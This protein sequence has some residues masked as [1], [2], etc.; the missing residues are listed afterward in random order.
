M[1]GQVRLD[2]AESVARVTLSHPGKLNAM[3]RVMWQQLR[4]VFEGIQQN[5]SLRCVIL[6]GEG[7][8]FCAGGDISEYADF[9][10][11]E[12]TLRQF[13]DELVW[14]GLQALLDCDVPVVAQI[15]GACMGAGLEIA[16]C[17]DLRIAGM[18]AKFG[19]PIAKLG[20]P[21]APR[22]LALVICAAGELS[23]REMLLSAAVLD[24]PTAAQRG[25]LNRVS[26]DT[27]V[28][29]EA[30]AMA[31]RVAR[32]APQAARLNKQSFRALAHTQRALAAT[33]LI[34]NAYAY[35]ASAEHREG[36]TAFV[37]KRSPQF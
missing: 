26:P 17:C 13:H 32:L 19:A 23:A 33:D 18:S 2:I 4:Q 12:A 1:T 22:E 14:G 37:D 7:G 31:S 27:E 6:A 28:A 34:A 9:R 35:A 8:N 30:V 25:F 10:F 15:E 16:S 36:V 29:D 11:E 21:M 3:S 5:A 20:F 24:A